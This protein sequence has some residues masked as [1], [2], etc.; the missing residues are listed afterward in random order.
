MRE[1]VDRAKVE[2]VLRSLGAAAD[3]DVRI[4]FTGG[5][6][7]VLLGWR[8]ST[9]DIDFV[10]VPDSG[11][12]LQAIPALKESLAVNVE[13]ASPAH[14]VP[15]PAGWEAK[16]ALAMQCRAASPLAAYR[17]RLLRMVIDGNLAKGE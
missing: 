12:L 5:V 14:F 11:T 2:R 1:V 3:R 13:I 16:P 7:A 8:P 10:A 6:T 9:V 4:Y 17:G 15:V